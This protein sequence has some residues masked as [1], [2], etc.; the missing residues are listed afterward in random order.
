MYSLR[1]ERQFSK[2]D[3]KDRA[4][5]RVTDHH[6]TD[7]APWPHFRPPMALRRMGS[8]SSHTWVRKGVS[9]ALLEAVGYVWYVHPRLAISIRVK[10]SR[11]IKASSLTV[12]SRSRR[13][14]RN[15]ASVESDA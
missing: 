1:A 11:S 7:H 15:D 8:G 13:F 12:L 4:E 9:A 6:Y 2:E 5:Y 3:G 10:S 14:C